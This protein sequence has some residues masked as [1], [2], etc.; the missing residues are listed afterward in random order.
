MKKILLFAV[1]LLLLFTLLPIAPIAA[2]G[3]KPKER[4]EVTVSGD[5]TSDEVTY[6]LDIRRAGRLV[7]VYGSADDLTFNDR[8]DRETED[9]VKLG[10]ECSWDYFEGAGLHE[11][12]GLGIRIDKSGETEIFYE[13]DRTVEVEGSKK[14]WFKYQLTGSGIWSDESIP[15]GEI[16]VTGETF[17]INEMFYER[18]SKKKGK[19]AIGVTYVPVWSGSLSFTITIDE[20]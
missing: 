11:E 2:P 15:Y 1:M 7:I 19:G 13:F 3:P 6:T 17:T 20:I 4:A 14:L 12:G 9:W 16:T 10:T 5:I 8:G 18:T